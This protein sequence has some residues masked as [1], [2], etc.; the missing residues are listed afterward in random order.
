[1]K[2]LITGDTSIS[3]EFGNS[4]G[5][6]INRQVRNLKEWV[7]KEQIAGI[8]EMIPTFCSLMIQ[9][10]PQIIRYEELADKVQGYSG[11]VLGNANEKKRIVEIPVCYG[12]EFGPDL[13]FVAE[14]TGLS[15]QEVIRRHA[16]RD[17]MIYMLGF[18]PGF[19]YLGGMNTSLIVPRLQKPRIKIEAGSVGIGGEQTGIYPIDSPGGWQLIGKTPVKPYDSDREQPFLYQAGDYIR[20]LSIEKEE[21]HEIEALLSEKKYECKIITE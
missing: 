18:L 15:E 19:A 3:V 5:E 11:V 21:F 8:T 12:G 2:I 9:Y 4:I 13:A 7:K 20:F 6:D 16:G 1:M 14:H 17:Y 10:N